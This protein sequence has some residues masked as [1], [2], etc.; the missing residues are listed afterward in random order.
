MEMEGSVEKNLRKLSR[1]RTC[2]RRIMEEPLLANAKTLFPVNTIVLLSL[3]VHCATALQA[4]DE[5]KRIIK[6]YYQLVRSFI[7]FD[8]N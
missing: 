2:C 4:C 7:E 6:N 3:Y 8:Q 5:E 1:Q